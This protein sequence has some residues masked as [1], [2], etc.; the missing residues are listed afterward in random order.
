VDID[1][2]A[3]AIVF[4]PDCSVGKD[5]YVDGVA[6]SGKGLVHRIVDDFIDEVVE[7]PWAGR[8]D[9][10]SGSLANRFQTLENLDIVGTVFVFRLP[11]PN[12]LRHDWG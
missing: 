12:R 5:T 3:A 7:S 2:N 10:H 6:V 9:I 4:D 1:R 11:F 8:T